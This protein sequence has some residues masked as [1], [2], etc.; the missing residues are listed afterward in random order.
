M[1]TLRILSVA[2]A[3]T[4]LHIHLAGAAPARAWTLGAPV[5]SY[6]AG[7]GYPGGSPMTDAAAVQLAEGGWNLVW[8]REKELDVAQRRGL[9][10][11][12]TDPL[13]DPAVLDDPKRSEA[14]DAL[15][16]RVASHPAMYAYHLV[17]EPSA[18]NFPAL[19][20]L[21]ARLR[22]R[23]PGHLAYINLFP[24]YASNKQLGTKGNTVDAYNEHL[25]QFVETVRPGLLSYDHYQFFNGGD[26]PDYFLNLELIRR[27]ALAADLPFMNIVQASCWVPGSAANPNAPRVPTGE[28]MRYL[29]Y[30]TLAYGAQAISYYV[31]CYPGHEGG[32]ARPD[33]TPTPLYDAL[34]PL[35]H[36]FA[37]IAKELQPLKS[38]GVFHAGMIPPG[39]QALPAQAAFAFDPPVPPMT[40][41]PRERV[42]GVLLS[43]FGIPDK[44]PAA[45]T[46]VLVVNLDYKAARTVGLK[47]PGALEVFDADAGQWAPA[48]GPRVELQLPGGGGKLLRVR[49]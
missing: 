40:G 34:K 44:A 16:A 23:D 48:G 3:A 32:I 13:L 1:K 31:Y 8:C 35:N 24:T 2:L 4:C 38:L 25:R 46:H 43:R 41:K 9:R 14:L 39:T 29:V 42:Q 45:G 10:A 19:G 47:G 28:E 49:P 26:N 27:K 6:W 37:A 5:V 7:P 11:L 17:D 18:E 22:E 12:L 15:M 36:Q 33:G 21:V 20:R 30:T